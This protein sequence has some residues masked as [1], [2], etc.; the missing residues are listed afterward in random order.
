MPLEIERKFLVDS[1]DD[2]RWMIKKSKIIKQGYFLGGKNGIARIRVVDNGNR[3]IIGLKSSGA[4]ISREEIEIPVTMSAEE[5]EAALALCD[6]VI[7]K[8]RHIV[9]HHEDPSLF[10][11]VDEFFGENAGLVVAEI[12][13]RSED[14]L[15]SLPSWVGQ[16]VTDDSRYTNANLILKPYRSW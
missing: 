2:W 16:E 5:I 9:P 11:E 10:W 12:E 3:V 15:F 6:G 1:A 13:L 4:G 7:D 8:V 14:Q